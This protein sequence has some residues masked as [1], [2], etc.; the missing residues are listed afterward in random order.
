MES[1]AFFILTLSCIVYF[2]YVDS[3]FVLLIGGMR[4]IYVVLSYFLDFLN[5]PIK[6]RYSRKVFCVIQIVALMLPFT[7]LLNNSLLYII[8]FLSFVLLL[9]SFSRDAFEQ[10]FHT[11]LRD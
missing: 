3:V 8:L 10:F 11:P 9:F 7:E 1:D 2:Y 6:E 5:N 4:Y